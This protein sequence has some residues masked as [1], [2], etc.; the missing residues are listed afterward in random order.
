[1]VILHLCLLKRRAL[2]AMEEGLNLALIPL[3]T[4]APSEGLQF[5]PFEITLEDSGGTHDQSSATSSTTTS[6]GK[7]GQAPVSTF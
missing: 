1:M 7:Q 3:T 5:Q 6:E 4:V 2:A